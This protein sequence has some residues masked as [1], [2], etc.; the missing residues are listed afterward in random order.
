M[1]FF[2]ISKFARIC[3]SWIFPTAFSHQTGEGFHWRY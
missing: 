2:H 1:L 3:L